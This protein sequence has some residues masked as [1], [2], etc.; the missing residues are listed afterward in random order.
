MKSPSKSEI[1]WA[2]KEKYMEMKQS[3]WN[4]AETSWEDQQWKTDSRQ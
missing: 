4:D 1:E 2:A 3:L